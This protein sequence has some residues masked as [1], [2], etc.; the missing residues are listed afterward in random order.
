MTT[1]IHECVADRIVIRNL[2][3]RCVIGVED[4]ERRMAQRLVVDIELQGDFSAAAESDDISAAVDY[5][6]VC[7][8]TRE[9]AE[10]C[11]YR[12]LE[13]LA[14]RIANSVLGIHGCVRAVTV[15]VFKPLALAGY[16]AA[17]S[18]VE[19]TRSL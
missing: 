7:A 10:S 8:A 5:R 2:E 14:D 6:T 16:G 9:I 4:W 1:S 13:T 17:K 11:E 3:L 12:L 18:R 19:V 15:S